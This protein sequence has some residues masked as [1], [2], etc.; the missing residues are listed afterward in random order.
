M[1]MNDL[2]KLPRGQGSFSMKRGKLCYKKNIKYK[3]GSSKEH[4]V[5]GDTVKECIDKMFEFEHKAE[6]I[7]KKEKIINN[8]LES[9]ILDWLKYYKK[10]ELK[11]QSYQR[12]E[13][14]IRNQILTSG[15]AKYSY[16]SISTDEIQ[17]LIIKL[18]EKGLS[19]SSIKKTYDCLN[20]FYRY[21]SAKEDIKNPML[22]VTMPSKDNIIKGKSKAIEFLDE[23]DIK[24]FIQESK[25]KWNTGNPRYSGGLVYSA[26]IF[27]GLRIG[28][29]L[30]LT[31]EDIDFEN[32]TVRVNKT[33][34]EYVNT[35]GRTI[36]E[37][38][39]TTKTNINRYVPL[40]NRAK[41]LLLEYKT[42]KSN[43]EP[44]NYVISTRTGK[45]TTIKNASD[46]IKSIELNAKT[47]VQ[48]G[49]THVLRHTCASLYFK[50]GISV[51]VIAK[52][53]GHSPE[54][55]RNT[56]I[57]FI[58]EQLKEAASKIEL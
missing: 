33:L 58:E 29:L 49:S 46:T 51:E 41:E 32:N 45:T 31:W 50:K 4:Y 13:S 9:T 14:T 15:L 55:C 48:G 27:M 20:G 21:I 24:L 2:P 43:T 54:V 53:L 17:K 10:P 6:S 8:T 7:H 35:N 39:P 16:S 12:L 1:R 34:I 44:Q 30:A 56:Y 18:N 3:D 22:L 28:E 57:H 19:Y 40:N 23:K 11:P 52:I 37:I 26:N 38:Q 36:F 5:Y 25:K 47:K 42:L